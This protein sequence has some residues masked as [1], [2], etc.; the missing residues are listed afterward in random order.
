ME[1]EKEEDKKMKK[2]KKKDQDNDVKM[3]EDSKPLSKRGS[4][5]L[6]AHRDKSRPY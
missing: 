5:K 3:S 4:S 1:I 6:K 2:E